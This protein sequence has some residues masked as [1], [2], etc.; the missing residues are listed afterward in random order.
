MTYVLTFT[1]NTDSYSQNSQLEGIREALLN[2]CEIHKIEEEIS[3]ERVDE[4]VQEAIDSGCDNFMCLCESEDKALLEEA[5]QEEYEKYFEKID[6]IKEEFQRF[7]EISNTELNGGNPARAK[8]QQSRQTILRQQ[9]RQ[10]QQPVTNGNS[11]TMANIVM[12]NISYP[13]P[14]LIDKWLNKVA[15]L[16]YPVPKTGGRA[17]NIICECNAIT[18]QGLRGSDVIELAKQ[19]PE[20]NFR[21]RFE[22]IE[23]AKFKNGG[24][25]IS[26]VNCTNYTD[27]A[28]VL[29]LFQFVTTGNNISVINLFAPEGFSTYSTGVIPGLVNKS[30]QQVRLNVFPQL[31][32][33]DSNRNG[34]V[35]D[36]LR[37]LVEGE[38]NSYKGMKSSTS[39]EIE[40]Q[41]KADNKGLTGK[42]LQAAVAEIKKDPYSAEAQT[43]WPSFIK[44]LTDRTKVF[45]QEGEVKEQ[46]DETKIEQYKSAVAGQIKAALQAEAKMWTD[47]FDTAIPLSSI[48]NLVKNITKDVSHLGSLKKT[49]K[50]SDKQKI[51][52]NKIRTDA[53]LIVR[54]AFSGNFNAEEFQKNC[55]KQTVTESKLGELIKSQET[56]QNNLT[57]VSK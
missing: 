16:N 12:Y 40:K 4:A 20:T 39:A 13:F 30:G 17:K 48:I 31:P 6:V 50:K 54:K 27:R 19:I 47:F 10:R 29:R 14:D 24:Q 2:D 18:G 3:F 15:S 26:R 37:Q 8:V 42:D 33:F 1:E 51:L 9:P 22:S 34:P 7:K 5:L 45:L 43:Q 44:A 25:V 32:T 38:T 28:A 55:I 57:K 46:M 21:E 35:L 11:Y 53:Y 52:E 41:L 49:L 23:N 56:A 36:A